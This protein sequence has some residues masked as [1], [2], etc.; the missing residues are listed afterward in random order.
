MVER[1][2]P[3]SMRKEEK[4]AAA[5]EKAAAKAEAEKQKEEDQ[6]K[7]AAAKA[8]KAFEARRATVQSIEFEAIASGEMDAIIRSRIEAEYGEEPRSA[9]S[10]AFQLLGLLPQDVDWID[11]LVEFKRSRRVAATNAPR[12]ADGNRAAARRLD[13]SRDVEKQR[14]PRA[15]ARRRRT[16]VSP[17]LPRA[18]RRPSTLSPPSVERAPSKAASA[19]VGAAQAARARRFCASRTPTMEPAAQSSLRT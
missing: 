6:A 3:Q 7:E 12:C 17:E 13:D 16:S 19:L 18:T 2:K 14:A 11:T 5:A 15:S 4:R 1:L 9:R 10:R 8:A